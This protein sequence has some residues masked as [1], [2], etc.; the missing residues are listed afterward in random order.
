METPRIFLGYD[1]RE[2]AGFHVCMQSLIENSKGPLAISALTGEQRDGTNAFIYARFLVPYLCGYQGWAIFADGSDMIF[3]EDV[4]RLWE[5]RNH[6]AVSVVQRNYV[7]KHARKYLGTPMEA[8]NF[9]YPK[10]NWS[11]LML[12]NCEHPA[13][14]ILTPAYVAKQPGSVLHRF[15]WLDGLAEVGSLPLRWN[16]LIDEDGESPDCAVAH[17]TLGIPSMCYYGDREIEREWWALHDR[18]QRTG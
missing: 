2:A 6:F 9:N 1:K 17:F 15:A 8:D 7:S 11:S 16:V 18:M 13:N 4:H 14:R 3:R 10:K 5:M 12:F